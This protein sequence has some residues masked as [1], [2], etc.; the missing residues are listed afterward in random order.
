M[1][2]WKFDTLQVHA[3]QEPEKVFGSRAL[4]IHQTTAYVFESSAQAANRFALAEGGTIYTRLMNPTTDAIEAKIAALEGGAAGILL[5]SG[6][7]AITLALLN[8]AQAGDHIVASPSLYGGSINLLKVTLKQLGISTTFVNDPNDPQQW[9]DA[10]QDN[11]KAFYGET[12]PNPKG[13]ILDIEPIAEVAHAAGVPLIVDNTVP[14]PY[15]LRP[16]DFGADVVVHSATKYLGGHGTSLAGAIIEKGDFN[17]KNGRFPGFEQPDDSYHGVVFGDLGPGA[18]VTR[19]RTTLLRDV[20]PAAAPFNA[21]LIGQGIETLSLR[22]DRHVSNAKAVAEFLQGRDEVEAVHYSS[23]ATSPYYDLAQK[24]VPKGASGLLNFDIKG[25]REAGEK[26]ADALRLHSI[27]ANIGDTRSLVIH[28][29]STTHSQLTDD[30][31]A[32]AGVRPGTVR[33]SVGIEDIEDI[34]AD[35]RIGFAAIAES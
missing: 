22:M 24:Y 29:A 35:L 17:W 5:A 9:A 23:L 34:L 7:S 2:N 13:D 16:F 6:Q 1:S 4:P 8:V 30:E 21:W 10:V 14:T 33:L 27:V 19:I 15:L 20:G 28:P 11:T 12:I 18:Y 32:A 25:G 3:G 26:F 31:L